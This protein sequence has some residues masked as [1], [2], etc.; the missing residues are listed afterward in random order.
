MIP[1][2][3]EEGTPQDKNLEKVQ[4]NGK[5]H[6]TNLGPELPAS[7]YAKEQKKCIYYDLKCNTANIVRNQKAGKFETHQKIFDPFQKQQFKV[8]GPEL[9]FDK[10]IVNQTVPPPIPQ[11]TYK[12]L[13]KVPAPNDH[14]SR[15][16]RSS[17]FGE[18]GIQYKR[19]DKREDKPIQANENDK[20]CTQNTQG[21]KLS[22][23]DNTISPPVPA[24]TYKNLIQSKEGPLKK[25]RKRSSSLSDLD[26][27]CGCKK[28][29]ET[30]DIGVQTLFKE[31]PP[32][33][34]PDRT[35]KDKINLLTTSKGNS[36]ELNHIECI[37]ATCTGEGESYCLPP[38]AQYPAHS[39]GSSP[40]KES[41]AFLDVRDLSDIRGRSS[42]FG[43]FGIKTR[44]HKKKSESTQLKRTNNILS[45]HSDIPT[46]SR[47]RSSSFGEYGTK[48]PRDKL[49]QVSTSF[50]QQN[51]APLLHTSTSHLDNKKCD[52]FG[53]LRTKSH[54]HRKKSPKQTRN[55]KFQSTSSLNLKQDDDLKL[56]ETRERTSSFSKFEMHSRKEMSILTQKRGSESRRSHDRIMQENMTMQNT[57]RQSKQ[58]ISRPAILI[59]SPDSDMESRKRARKYKDNISYHHSNS[60]RMN[61]RKPA[62]Q[63][64]TDYEIQRNHTRTTSDKTSQ[65]NLKRR[66]ETE[67][68]F[69]EK[70]RARSN[71]FSQLAKPMAKLSLLDRSISETNVDI[72]SEKQKQMNINKAKSN[73]S[74]VS[75]G[76]KTTASTLD[77]F[78]SSKDNAQR[79]DLSP[80]DRQRSK[81]FSQ[82][83]KRHPETTNRFDPAKDSKPTTGHLLQVPQTDPGTPE[84]ASQDD[85]DGFEPQFR[86][87]C[88]SFSGMR[89]VQRLALT[90]PPPEGSDRLQARLQ[91]TSAG[92]EELHILREKQRLLVEEAKKSKLG[93]TEGIRPRS[94][95]FDPSQLQK[96]KVTCYFFFKKKSITRITLILIYNYVSGDTII[97]VHYCSQGKFLDSN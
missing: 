67:E 10:E 14:S 35:Y 9:A 38:D 33:P 7:T 77:D 86:Q 11:R 30:K 65:E 15:R 75:D 28:L 58:T 62:N 19:S 81:S 54:K 64:T 24:R 16:P 94:N 43:E 42:S 74:R 17:S 89:L 73:S 8:Y 50:Q 1:N 44:R 87:R 36:S 82:V 6:K 76:F 18:F 2:G 55:S 52:S 3:K 63:M 27:N 20:D 68:H 66:V 69:R 40:V 23:T 61:P 51:D 59:T 45:K 49:K 96:N 84:I 97:R 95:T 5:T 85:I 91:A 37:T 26:D 60:Q 22:H 39:C 31:V 32:I 21:V 34:L 41:S 71:S 88:H 56:P 93:K 57:G 48:K 92:L 46:R 53:E 13:L 72:E 12:N 70:Q 79:E 80:Q 25:Q 90:S 4:D 83:T 47:L 78:N 29:T